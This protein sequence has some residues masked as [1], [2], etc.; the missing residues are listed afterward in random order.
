M[1]ASDSSTIQVFAGGFALSVAGGDGGGVALSFGASVA[2]NNIGNTIEALVTDAN[3]SGTGGVKVSATEAA[4]IEALT[5]AGSFSIATGDG[6]AAG[7]AGAGAGSGNTIANTTSA[8]IVDG[9]LV[10]SGPGG[11]VQVTASDTSGITANA[12]S[13][14]VT[15]AISEGGGLGGAVGAAVAV[16]TISNSVAAYVDDSTVTSGARSRSAPR[17]TT[18]Y[19][20]SRSAWRSP[21]PA[22][23]AV[24]SLSPV[25]APV[26]A[27]PFPIRSWRPSRMAAP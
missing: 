7:F 11:L 23:M 20:P 24:A 16:N 8:K 21:L 2:I 18:T 1:S 15:V 10:T 14:A 9:S 4:Q 27:T 25:P 3:V 6:G 22:G 13:V 5:I 19:S 17:P 12:G 26:P